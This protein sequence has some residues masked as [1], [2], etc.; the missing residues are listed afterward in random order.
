[1]AA[2]ITTIAGR[3]TATF[4]PAAAGAAATGV[5]EDPGWRLGI[6]PSWLA[7]DKTDAYADAV[8]ETIWRGFSSI[9]IDWRFREWN[10]PAVRAVN[11][12]SNYVTSGAGTFK[13]GVVGR[14]GSALGGALI[15]TATAATP[16]AASPATATFSTIHMRP[17]Y[18]T[19][20][21]YGPV[22]RTTPVSM[23]VLPYDAGSGAAEYFSST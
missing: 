2:V 17:G 21:V 10:V 18:S 14:L 6:T 23:L 16:A 13:P 20:W 9:T 22:E 11:P 19:E 4:N 15:M 7:V 3:Y 1:M 12:G 5:L 8:I